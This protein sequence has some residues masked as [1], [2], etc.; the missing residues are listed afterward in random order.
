[1]KRTL[2][3]VLMVSALVAIPT[4]AAAG[5]SPSAGCDRANNPQLD[6]QYSFGNFGIFS[7]LADL[8]AGEVLVFHSGLPENFGPATGIQLFVDTAPFTGAVE[9]NAD[10]FPG[11]LVYVVPADE[12]TFVSWGSIPGNATTWDVSCSATRGKG[13]PKVTVCHHGKKTKSVGLGA[14]DAHFGHGDT[15]GSCP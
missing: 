8:A 6:S 11:T 5:D 4:S 14:A 10:G 1:M 7:P 13:G 2:A 9:V 15:G 12:L 3:L